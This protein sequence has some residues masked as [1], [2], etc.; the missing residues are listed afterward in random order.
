MA[1]LPAM[2]AAQPEPIDMD[3]LSAC[4]E[5]RDLIRRFKDIGLG[6]SCSADVQTLA[7][8]VDGG[9]LNNFPVDLM[10]DTGEGPV[11]GCDLT[12]STDDDGA[13]SLPPAPVPL[14]RFLLGTSARELPDI[15][16]TLTRTST[17]G[18]FQA[19]MASREAEVIS[20]QDD[21]EDKTDRL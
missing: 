12:T 20:V 7:L 6:V 16:Q 17:L 9:V 3:R 4:G 19:A 1:C 10:M 13:V 21:V 8:L 14:L 5:L 2:C 11:V 15:F 18:S